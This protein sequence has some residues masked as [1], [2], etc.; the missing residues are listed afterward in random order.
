MQGRTIHGVDIGK[1][2]LQIIYF[3]NDIWLERFKRLQDE[4]KSDNLV[5]STGLNQSQ[6]L[7][8]M[9]SY[10]PDD[11]LIVQDDLLEKIYAQIKPHDLQIQAS[12]SHVIWFILS[13]D[14][15]FRFYD[16]PL[17]P[18]IR[19]ILDSDSEEKE[20]ITKILDIKIKCFKK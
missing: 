15:G 2:Y 9:K 8:A 5:P 17:Y 19:T 12:S 18:E 1:K 14:L 10:N 16:N 3:E 7:Q 13:V 11:K 6:L 4:Y 20:K